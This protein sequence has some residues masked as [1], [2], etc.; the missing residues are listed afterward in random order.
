MAPG[1]ARDRKDR[2]GDSKLLHDCEQY[3]QPETEH[4]GGTGRCS[5]ISRSP[6]A[7]SLS[8]CIAYVPGRKNSL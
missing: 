7:I 4:D 8:M 3:G 6:A 5:H 2:E 1:A